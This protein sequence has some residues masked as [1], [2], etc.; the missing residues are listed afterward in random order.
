MIPFRNSEILIWDRE[1]G[2]RVFLISLISVPITHLYFKRPFSTRCRPKTGGILQ[3]SPGIT[4]QA[5]LYS[6][7][8]RT[9]VPCA[10][11]SPPIHAQSSNTTPNTTPNPNPNPKAQAANLEDRRP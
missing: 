10:F 6:L 2:V 3:A 9:T 8:L 4:F 7:P 11:G 5:G 1:T